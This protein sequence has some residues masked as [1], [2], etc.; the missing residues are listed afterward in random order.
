MTTARAPAD[1]RSGDSPRRELA[2]AGWFRI[3]MLGGGE[4]FVE[5]QVYVGGA[6]AVIAQARPQ[7]GVPAGILEAAPG[8]I[9]AAT[10]PRGGI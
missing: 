8:H 2:V 7:Y 6:G 10:H 4:D 9:P 3:E 1:I 5:Q